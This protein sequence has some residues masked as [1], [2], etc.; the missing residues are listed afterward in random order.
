MHRLVVL[1]PSRT[2]QQ[3]PLGW[4]LSWKPVEFHQLAR[5]RRPALGG[6]Y[7]VVRA[8][9]EQLA[10]DVPEEDGVV[11]GEGEDVPLEQQRRGVPAPHV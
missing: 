11:L 1:V 7:R 8:E 10:V 6:P 4:G 3:E 2:Q 5:E 9:R